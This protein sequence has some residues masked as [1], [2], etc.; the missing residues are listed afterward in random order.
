M[1]AHRRSEE[2]Q[3][4]LIHLKILFIFRLARIQALSHICVDAYMFDYDEE[5]ANASIYE[6]FEEMAPILN[7]T[8][9]V[10]AWKEDDSDDSCSRIFVPI[11]TEEGLCFT[12]NALNS[13]EIYTDK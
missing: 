10:C 2:K 6:T 9:R 1:I 12:F 4:L 13:A 8:L 7:D 11:S 5:L 3:L